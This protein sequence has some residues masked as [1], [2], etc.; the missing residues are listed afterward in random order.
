MGAHEIPDEYRNH[1]KKYIDI[2]IKEMIPAVAEEKLAVFCDVF[3][4]K[5]VFTVEESE[6]ILLTAKAHGLIPKLHAD[7]LHYTGG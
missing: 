1:R 3:C 2:L 6:R 5:D 7:E 4:E